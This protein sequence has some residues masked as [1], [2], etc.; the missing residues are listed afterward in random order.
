MV[1]NF[2]DNKGTFKVKNAHLYP[3]LYL[4]LTNRNGTLLSSI[5]PKLA[6][7]IKRDNG[8]FLTPPASIEDIKHNLL[9]RR[10]FFLM[11]SNSKKL[12]RISEH[13]KSYL[14]I[15]MLYQKLISMHPQVKIITTN[16]IPPNL[17]AEVMWIKIKNLTKKNISFTPTSFLP[18]Y[19]RSEKNLHDHRHV[20]SLLN[21]I[22]FKKYGVILKPTLSFDETGH[23]LNKTSYFV[24]GYLNNSIPPIGFFP[25]LES[26][27]KETGTLLMPK[28]VIN[29]LPSYKKKQKIF[30]GK[31][32]CAALRFKRIILKPLKEVNFILI[33]GITDKEETIARTFSALNTVEKIKK[34]LEE[35]KKYWQM[36]VAHLEI[37]FGN[38]DYDN[39]IK[40]VI[41]QPTL[42]KLFGCSFLP[43]FDYGKGGRGWRDLWQ[44]ALNLLRIEPD[45]T[46][47]LILRNFCGVRI[48][49][50]NATIITKEN[51]FISDRNKISRVWM[52]HGVWPF[53]IL[54]EYI[55]TTGNLKILLQKS[56][57]YRDHQIKRAKELDYNF[58]PKDNTLKTGDN[59]TYKGNILEH[60]LVELLVPFFNVGKHNFIRLE[61]A[62]WNDGLDMASD[63]GESVT[64]SCMYAYNLE[65]L[66]F[67]LEK[68]TKTHTY[69]E[70]F[71]ELTILLD[72]LTKCPIDYNN[73]QKKQTLLNRYLEKTKYTITG[74]TYRISLK[75]LIYDLKEKAHW[76]KNHIRKY[77]WL[78]E[79]FYNGYYDNKGKRVEGKKGN[80]IRM[81]L[82]S[83]VFAIMSGVATQQQIKSIWESI[84][85]YLYDRNLKG[86]RLNTDFHYLYM[87]LGRAFSFSYGDKENGAFFNHMI[88]ML[89]FSLY[90]R[91]FAK[92]GNKVFTTLYKMATAKKA[93]IYPMLPEYFNAQGQ[94]LYFYL[95]GSA[96]WYIYTLMNK[97]LGIQ[98]L[99]GD[100]IINPQL[101]PANFFTNKISCIFQ[102]KNKRINITYTIK[103]KKAEVYKIHEAYL[104]GKKLTPTRNKIVIPKN[105]FSLLSSK[106][107][108][109]IDVFLQ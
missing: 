29:N 42:R 108:Y 62:D 6:G 53:L 4:P 89:A 74:K 61:N 38:P 65:E 24:L 86:Y 11:F 64:F 13:K 101:T 36:V 79:G 9:C 102:W 92:E 60:L 100:M 34:T 81:L 25:T 82:P 103:H 75:S 47:K 59:K 48:D 84:K 27:C 99:F 87:D 32:C 54:K 40:W 31:E 68:F 97:I 19:G 78:K 15:G 12:L 37:S 83:Q 98:F 10:D 28:A 80:I 2:I 39:W 26:F 17:D 56:F 1:Y 22:Y 18:L 96:S 23:H 106:K 77:A 8:H 55:N 43:H 50:S 70:I 95:T 14:E 16:F 7:D 85:K 49:G 88:V 3:Y 20:T 104:E 35:T 90:N 72:R 91:G 105:I 45:K 21:R 63:D 58:V 5:S 44:D 57:Y 41:L 51:N 71:K 67:L 94:G 30:D 69:V 109:L 46:H 66:A 93:K 33:M 73:P 107:N 52:D 76:L